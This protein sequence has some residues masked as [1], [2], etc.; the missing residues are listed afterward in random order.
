LPG[1]IVKLSNTYRFIPLALIPRPPHPSLVS[2]IQIY[3]NKSPAAKETVSIADD[4]VATA[5]ETVSA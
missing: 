2:L 3:M 5:E 4:I 1:R